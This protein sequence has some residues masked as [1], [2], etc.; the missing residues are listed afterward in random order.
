MWIS[1]VTDF[2]REIRRYLKTSGW[3]LHRQAKGDHEIW[4]NPTMGLKVMVDGKVRNRALAN[5]IL[6]DA[7]IGKKF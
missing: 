1:T 4:I 7:L 5:K 2:T 3:Y 6:K